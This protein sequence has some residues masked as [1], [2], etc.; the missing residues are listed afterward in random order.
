MDYLSGRIIELNLSIHTYEL[1]IQMTVRTTRKYQM[2]NL[3]A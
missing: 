1:P 2:M 3:R